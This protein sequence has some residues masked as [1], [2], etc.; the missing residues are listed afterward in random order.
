M[1][2]FLAVNVLLALPAL[3]FGQP[4]RDTSARPSAQT[5]TAAI[6]GR[7][8]AGDTGKPLRR[9]RIT[10][11]AAE[12]GGEPRNTST[13][14]DGRFELA[15]LPAGLYNVRVS[16]SG[17]LTLRYGQRRPG[18]LGKPLQLL[19]AQILDRVDFTLPRMGLITGRILDDNN[20]PIE[21]VN[22]FALRAMYFNGRR[23]YV[24]TGESPQVQ[25]DDAG[26]YRLLGLAPGSYIVRAM[27]RET[28][29]VTRGN[30]S[31]VM[32]YVPT[33]FPGTTAMAQ[34]RKVTVRLGQEALNTDFALVPG[35]AAT[36]SGRAVD[37]RGRPF[38][39]VSVRQEIRGESFGSFGQIASTTA[40][41]DG[42]FTIRHVPPGEY[43][44]G[45]STGSDRSD[46][47]VAMMPLTV[48]GTDIDNIVLTGSAGGLVSGQVVT[49]EGAVPTIPRLRI[50]AVEF[51]RG[52]PSPMILGAFR[53]AGRSEIAEDGTF[54]INGVF[55]RS[56]LR[57]IG[58]PEDWAVK[59]VLHDGRD[60]A[61]TPIELRSGETMTGVQVILTR[62]ITSLTGQ[63]TDAKGAPL[64]DGTVVVFST[65]P[66]RWV[67]DS[68][69]VRAAR[70][71]Q[72]GL[73]RIKGLPPDEYFVVAVETVE[74][75]QW[76]ESEFLEAIRRYAEKVQLAEAGSETV[77]LKLVTLDP[78]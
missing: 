25:T 18:E 24:P 13:D 43:L 12:L 30:T 42:S 76:F 34:A 70:P 69:F 11:T 9:V 71:D 17:Y 74:E 67:D 47:E 55:G 72:Q 26:Q 40:A 52:Q 32:G 59:A 50:S 56:R 1:R 35:R 57:L 22:V 48:D 46:P 66:Q 8:V 63:L 49:E 41:A 62:R 36:L 27:T 58:L 20:E 60:V 16:R 23:Q 28:W 29:T 75:G 2:V 31:E 39:N 45:A 51:S 77:S 7:V 54:S 37:S 64:A 53:N 44:L 78:R 33:Y 4:P 3:A 14:A 6:R 15:G 38:Q 5:G 68:R 21:G 73:W 61:E 10:A 19:D 65:E